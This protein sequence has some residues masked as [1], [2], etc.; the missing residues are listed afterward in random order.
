MSLFSKIGKAIGGAVKGVTKSISISNITKLATGDLA[1]VTKSVA[2]KVLSNT[3]QAVTGKTAAPTTGVVP[4][5]TSPPRL[6]DKLAA[7]SNLVSSSIVKPATVS[8]AKTGLTG[9]ATIDAAI[10]GAL[11]GAGVSIGGT[12]AGNA[13]INATGWTAAKTWLKNNW[14]ALTASLAV[15]GGIV[16]AVFFRKPKT[17][18]RRTATKRR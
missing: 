3:V 8:T 5:S 10:G 18:V 17:G 16:W 14:I 4:V 15:V 1:G 6:A 12:D 7:V 13:A 2:N 11:A 9:N